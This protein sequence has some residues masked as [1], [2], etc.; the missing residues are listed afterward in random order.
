MRLIS[1]ALVLTSLLL[2]QWWAPATAQEE[3]EATAQEEEEEEEEG[4]AT[5]VAKELLE[6]MDKDKDSKLTLDE[7][8]A[9]MKDIAD[10]AQQ[11]H[12][13]LEK[14][15]E[16][17]RRLFLLSDKD[18][19]GKLDLDEV[20]ELE[21]LYMKELEEAF[22]NEDIEHTNSINALELGRVLRSFGFSRT[23]QKVQRLVE[24]I[25]FDGSGELEMN[26]FVKLMRQ[27]L[28]GEAK[29]RRD[30]FNLLDPGRNGRIQVDCLPQA[31]KI[32]D[33]VN[34]DRALLQDALA[35]A[36]PEDKKAITLGDFEVLYKHYR[37]AVVQEIRKNAGYGPKEIIQLSSIFAGYDKDKSG[38]IEHTELQKLIAQYFPDATKSRSQQIEIQKILASFNTGAKTGE[39]DFHKFVWLMRKCDDMRDEADVKEEAAVVKAAALSPEEVEGFRNLFA[40]SVNWTGELDLP[41]ISELLLRVIEL[42]DDETSELE[43]LVREVHPYGREVAR[44]PQ[45]IKL[46]KRLTDDNF[47]GLNEAADRNLRQAKARRQKNHTTKKDEQQ[48]CEKEAKKAEKERLRELC[49]QVQAEG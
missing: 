18:G 47:L 13:E 5:D 3:Q 37:R 46:V 15:E 29:K 31:V 22:T 10:E 43:N 42:N 39:L 17:L 24:E 30:V 27:L 21:T 28:Q 4:A 41:Q 14:H 36:I 7:I 40:S 9:G 49:E 44:F 2:A 38:T 8:L 19:D 20:R 33:E 35:A 34:P 12:D 16:T 11:G 45:F 1:L 26:E 6:S 32:L 23:L 25:D 48:Q